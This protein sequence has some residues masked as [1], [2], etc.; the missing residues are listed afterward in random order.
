MNGT[1]VTTEALNFRSQDLVASLQRFIDLRKLLKRRQRTLNQ[2]HKQTADALHRWCPFEQQNVP[3][4]D[5]IQVC[6]EFFFLTSEIYAS[7]LDITRDHET[8]V[9][10]LKVHGTYSRHCGILFTTYTYRVA[11]VCP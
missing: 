2:L 3:L 8:I 7:R 10:L 6:L 9:Q 5:S 11:P 1:R 4:A